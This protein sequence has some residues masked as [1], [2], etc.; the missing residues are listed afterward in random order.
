VQASALAHSPPSPPRRLADQDYRSFPSWSRPDTGHYRPA[1]ASSSSSYNTAFSSSYP[2]VSTMP[3]SRGSHLPERHNL[4]W[5]QAPAPRTTSPAPYSP[6]SSADAVRAT[7][8]ALYLDHN[9]RESKRRRYTDEIDVGPPRSQRTSSVEMAKPSHLPPSLAAL[10]IDR[11][12]EHGRL[13]RLGNTLPS[14]VATVDA[15]PN[16][17]RRPVVG[18]WH[19]R[20]DTAKHGRTDRLHVYSEQVRR[21]DGSR[22]RIPSE[23]S[24]PPDLGSS[25]P[26]AAKLSDGATP[27]ARLPRLS[28]LFK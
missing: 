19:V 1:T 25:V 26:M 5:D 17:V 12:L 6:P 27:P 4:Y 13:P 22:P 20:E 18:E 8:N 7:H 10:A 24:G 2:S 21:E 23:R 16:E 3:F 11:P 9:V 14:L 15:P 28:E